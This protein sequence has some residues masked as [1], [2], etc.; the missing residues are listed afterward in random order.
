[1]PGHLSPKA[2]RTLHLKKSCCIGWG[3]L[4]PGGSIMSIRTL[5]LASVEL[6]VGCFDGIFNTTPNH[7]LQCVVPLNRRC[8]STSKRILDRFTLWIMVSVLFILQEASGMLPCWS[9][10]NTLDVCRGWQGLAWSLLCHHLCVWIVHCKTLRGWWRL[11]HGV[12]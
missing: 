7:S 2:H 6:Y 11:R 12:D 8:E 9:W 4:V 3:G 10:L 1:M 5:Q